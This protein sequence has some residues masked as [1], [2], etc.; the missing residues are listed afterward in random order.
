MPRASGFNF[1][2][3]AHQPSSELSRIPNLYL[4]FSQKQNILSL[5]TSM[6]LTEIIVIVFVSHTTVCC[7]CLFDHATAV[8]FC[9]FLL[10]LIFFIFMYV[11]FSLL[12]SGSY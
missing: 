11:K 6:V 7:P 12:Q 9:Y 1:F 5:V 2:V 3:H 8:N 10:L 4:A